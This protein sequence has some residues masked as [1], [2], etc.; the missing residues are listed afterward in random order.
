MATKEMMEEAFP[1]DLNAVDGLVSATAY[2]KKALSAY[3]KAHKKSVSEYHDQTIRI[4]KPARRMRK[5][6]M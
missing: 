5:E 3:Y 1:P 2:T 4:R 6:R